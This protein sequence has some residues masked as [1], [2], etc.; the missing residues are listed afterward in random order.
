[1]SQPSFN[2][3]KIVEYAADTRKFEIDLFWRRSVFFWGFLITAFA[4][5]AV[6][7]KD[8]KDSDIVLAIAGFG[9]VCSVAWTLANR[10]SKYWQGAWE[11]K[12]ETYEEQVFGIHLFKE[13]YT[14]NKNELYW[15]GVWS[16]NWH[17]SVSRLATALS[18][19]TVGVWILLLFKAI[20]GISWPSF[21][22]GKVLIPII[23]VGYA[24]LM[25]I[26]GLTKNSPTK[27]SPSP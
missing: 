21:F 19:F 18:D 27:P 15:W 20:P 12:L 24:V 26:C 4:A 23:S 6:I 5:Y 8:T 9:L 3:E 17:Y 13:H 1:M 16:K 10:G 14:P 7:S 2:S 11:A 25:L 22:N